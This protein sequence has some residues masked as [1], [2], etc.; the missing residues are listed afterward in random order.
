LH[1]RIKVFCFIFAKK[2]LLNKNLAVGKGAGGRVGAAISL[3]GSESKH[4]ISDKE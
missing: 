3:A 2:R 1:A 4:V